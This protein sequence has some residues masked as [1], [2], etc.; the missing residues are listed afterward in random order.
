VFFLVEGGR[1]EAAQTLPVFA[2]ASIGDSYA[3]GEGDPVLVNGRYAWD[4]DPYCHR[5]SM[6]APWI[7]ASDATLV[8]PPTKVVKTN[9]ACSGATIVEGLIAPSAQLYEVA[10]WRASSLSG[11]ESALGK[12]T[13]PQ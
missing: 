11:S 5:S 3:S 10:Q 8:S 13:I 6:A 7:A 9:L 12:S 1:G 2:I 4:Q